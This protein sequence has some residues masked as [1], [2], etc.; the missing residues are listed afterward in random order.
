MR[1]GTML[2][3]ILPKGF[4]EASVDTLRE[5]FLAQEN[6]RGYLLNHGLPL[7][8]DEAQNVPTLFPEILHIIE[9][10]KAKGGSVHGLFLVLGIQ[11]NRTFEKDAGI[12][13]QKG[14]FRNEHAFQRRNRGPGR[15]GLRSALQRRDKTDRTGPALGPHGLC[16][17]NV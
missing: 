9:E 17:K 1:E 6:P 12:L 13:G 4:Y 16:Q 11:Q 7:F 14:A 3:R 10:R 8:I 2:R 15:R 5:T